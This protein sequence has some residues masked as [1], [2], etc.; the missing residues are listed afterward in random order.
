[1]KNENIFIRDFYNEFSKTLN[2]NGYN[3]RMLNILKWLVKFGVEPHYNALE[4]GCGPGH[5]TFNF[6][7]LIKTGKIVGVDISSENIKTAKELHKGNPNVEFIVSDMTDFTH[8]LKFDVILLPDVLEH[9][10]IAQHH[11]LFKILRSV[12]KDRGKII[13]HI[14]D[15]EYLEYIHVNRK[16]ELQVTD[17]PL[18]TDIISSSLKGTGLRITYL[19]S[20]SLEEIKNDYQVLCIEPNDLPYNYVKKPWDMSLKS[21]IRR[22]MD[23]L[24]GR[25]SLY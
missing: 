17:Q 14:P 1:M 25:K 4:V 3:Y 12:L 8:N 11:Q 21:K 13:V 18:H 15:P 2:S 9:I 16:D 19:E 23:K 22:K 20:Y 5:S 6:V 7:Q 24:K 10:L